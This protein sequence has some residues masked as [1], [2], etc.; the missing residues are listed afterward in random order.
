MVLPILEKV[1]T[2]PLSLRNR[3][4][5]ALAKLPKAYG[6]ESRLGRELQTVLDVADDARRELH[7]EYL[8]TEHLLL[9]LADRLKLWTGSAVGREASFLAFASAASQSA[10]SRSSR[11]LCVVRR[12]ASRCF[13]VSA[14]SS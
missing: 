7:D 11:R 3:A 8:S 1:G 10:E 6:S 14:S 5:G 9:A 13:Q 4:D 2:S 12:M